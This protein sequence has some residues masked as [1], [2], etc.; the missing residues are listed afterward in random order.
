MAARPPRRSAAS[1]NCFCVRLAYGRHFSSLSSVNISKMSLS[2]TVRCACSAQISRLSILLRPM[3]STRPGCLTA[4]NR[5]MPPWRRRWNTIGRSGANSDK[6]SCLVFQNN[7]DLPPASI[8]AHS[9]RFLCCTVM[10]TIGV[11]KLTTIRMFGDENCTEPFTLVG[12]RVDKFAAV[13][14]SEVRA[15]AAAKPILV[16]EAALAEYAHLVRSARARGARVVAFIPLI[17]APSMM[18]NAHRLTL[19]SCVSQPCFV[20]AN[21]LSTS[22]ARPM[23]PICGTAP[24]FLMVPICRQR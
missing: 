21:K 9:A 7:F 24:P 23:A 5:S 2:T 12:E 15:E 8:G 13:S 22:T 18:A 19:T 16:D 20:K 11:I 3:L 4:T 6:L 1:P 10:P 17:Y 14:D